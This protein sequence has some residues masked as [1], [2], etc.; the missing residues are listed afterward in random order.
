VNADLPD[1]YEVLARCDGFDWD[2][3]NAPKVLARHN[4]EPGECEQV[5][6]R[7]PLVVAFDER[8]SGPE[9]RWQALGQTL[10]DRKLY[11]VLTVRGT[12]IR[13]IAARDMKRR[14]RRKYAEAQASLEENPSL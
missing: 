9:Q 5:F 8:H 6:F 3:G 4:V 7:E 14:E 10:A 1:I 13:V 11:L 2:A 12:L